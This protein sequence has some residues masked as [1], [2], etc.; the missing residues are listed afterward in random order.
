MKTTG[1][2]LLPIDDGVLWCPNASQATPGMLDDL[3]L[4]AERFLDPL[5]KAAFLVCT[6]G[7]DEFKTGKAAL[8]RFQQKFAAM[9]ILDVGLMDEDLQDQ[10]I[11]ID[12][13]MPL[14]PFDLLAAVIAAKPPF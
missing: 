6:V 14:P 3:H 8:E 11:G 12:E 13:Q 7:P 4:P 9:V 5:D 1:T 10:P 2:N